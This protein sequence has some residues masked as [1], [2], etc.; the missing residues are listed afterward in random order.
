MPAVIAVSTGLRIGASTD[1]RAAPIAV[2]WADEVVLAGRRWGVGGDRSA[3]GRRR[4]VGGV[5]ACRRN[6]RARAGRGC[7]RRRVGG[8]RARRRAPGSRERRRCAGR[9]RRPQRGLHRR[10]RDLLEGPRRAPR[11]ARVARLAGRGVGREFGVAVRRARPGAPVL[12]RRPGAERPVAAGA[13]RPD[14]ARAHAS[15]LRRGRSGALPAAAREPPTR[16]RPTARGGQRPS[17]P[18]GVGVARSLDR[19]R[20]GAGRPLPPSRR[21]AAGAS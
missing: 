6:D 21:G 18:R 2:G 4:R 14:C 3:R 1:S 9:A 12:P 7:R 20:G 15:R 5:G 13:R 10:P 11:H 8:A 19:M 16:V 17:C